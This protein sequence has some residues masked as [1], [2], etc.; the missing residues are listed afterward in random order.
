MCYNLA[1][2]AQAFDG[3]Y[4]NQNINLAYN[5]AIFSAWKHLIENCTFQQSVMTKETRTQKVRWFINIYVLH[6]NTEMTE[7]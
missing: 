2:C 6:A 7:I 4:R 5:V 3:G 1:F